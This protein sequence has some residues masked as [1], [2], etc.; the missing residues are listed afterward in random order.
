MRGQVYRDDLV[1]WDF[2]IPA[3]ILISYYIREPEC[4]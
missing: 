3:L 4:L 1:V 2:I